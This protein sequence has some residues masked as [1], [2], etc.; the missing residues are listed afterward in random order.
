MRYV[1]LL[2]VVATDD[3]E[4]AEEAARSFVRENSGRLVFPRIPD[5]GLAE[6]TEPVSLPDGHD[7]ASMNAS[8]LVAVPRNS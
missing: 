3:D 6:Y 8:V 2:L 7:Y 1:P 4:N 5:R